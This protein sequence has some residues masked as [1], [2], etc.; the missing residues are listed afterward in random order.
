MRVPRYRIGLVPI[1]PL[2]KKLLIK[3]GMRVAL[4]NALAA[5][6]EKLRPL[7]D[8][9]TIVRTLERDLDVVQVFARDAAELKSVGPRAFRA[10][11]KDGLLWVCYPK[12]GANGGTDLNRDIL[13]E[14]L[15]NRGLVGVTLVAIDDTWSAMRFRRAEERKK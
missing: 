8:G 5:C 10:V 12:G 14:L 15:G 7:P 4:V 11:K 9:A 2:A 1:S 3:P 13:R 6:A